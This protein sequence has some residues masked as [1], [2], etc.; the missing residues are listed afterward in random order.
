MKGQH[1]K[2][3]QICIDPP[4][5]CLLSINEQTLEHHIVTQTLTG[6]SNKQ[7]QQRHLASL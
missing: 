6:S 7:L 1:M 3:Q 5:H 2:T 4:L